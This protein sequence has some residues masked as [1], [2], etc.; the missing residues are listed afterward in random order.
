MFEIIKWWIAWAKKGLVM[1]LLVTV[2]AASAGAVLVAWNVIGATGAQFFNIE[3]VTAKVF[4][5]VY[6]LFGFTLAL[7]VFTFTFV[8]TMPEFFGNDLK[9]LME[10]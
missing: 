5:V 9:R 8:K 3:P 7:A 1:F 2:A 6:Q 4:R 10:E